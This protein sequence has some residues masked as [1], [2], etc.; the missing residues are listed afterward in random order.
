MKKIIFA[1]CVI[2][3]ALLILNIL[4]HYLVCFFFEKDN[5]VLIES[6]RLWN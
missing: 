1:I 5:K 4:A 3:G 6:C 2:I